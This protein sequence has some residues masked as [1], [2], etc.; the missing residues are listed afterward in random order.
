MKNKK[1][2][3]ATAAGFVGV[4]SLHAAYPLF[5]DDAALVAPGETELVA[6]YEASFG[7]DEYFHA[8]P[9]EITHGFHPRLEGMFGTGFQVLDPRDNG[10]TER[11]LLDTIIALKALLIDQGELPFSLTIEGLVSLPTASESRGLGDGSVDAGV[12]L[13]ATREWERIALDLN[14]GYLFAEH[15]RGPRDDGDEWFF[16]TAVRHAT[17]D[18]VETFL[19]TFAEV[20]VGSTSDTIVTARAGANWEFRENLFAGGGIGPS[21]GSDSPDFVVTAGMMFVF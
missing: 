7:S 18:T 17:T 19:E 10:G 12:N 8:F 6:Y 21:F 16:G 1:I 11:G 3:V 13:A 14:A 9:V 4:T 5:V 20:T 2:I 15:F